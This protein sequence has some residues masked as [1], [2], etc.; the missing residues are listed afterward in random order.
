MILLKKL[1]NALNQVN[2]NT[3]TIYDDGGYDDYYCNECK[4]R[5]KED[6]YNHLKHVCYKCWFDN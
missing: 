1:Q 4:N 2:G 5:V 6:E 3:V